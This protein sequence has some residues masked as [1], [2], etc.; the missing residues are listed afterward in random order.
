MSED[1]S[2]AL[3]FQLLSGIKYLHAKL[4]VHRDIKPENIIVSN[5]NNSKQIKVNLIDFNVSR[6]YNNE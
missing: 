1:T 2:K 4:I 5:P 3:M 6:H